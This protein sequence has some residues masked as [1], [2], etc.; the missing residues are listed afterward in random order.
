MDKLTKED[1][2]I[3]NYGTLSS[4]NIDGSKDYGRQIALNIG[5]AVMVDIDLA[6]RE[7]HIPCGEKPIVRIEQDGGYITIVIPLEESV[8][9][10]SKIR[11]AEFDKPEKE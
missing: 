6:E 8:I 1:I 3:K 11:P 5:N 9:M 10:D 2:R 7:I 4:I